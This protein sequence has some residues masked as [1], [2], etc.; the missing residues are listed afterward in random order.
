MPNTV[1]MNL[2]AVPAVSMAAPLRSM[3]CRVTCWRGGDVRLRWSAAGLLE[4]EKNFRR[5]RGCK[6]M[7]KLL[8]ALDRGAVAESA[9]AA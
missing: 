1:S 2:P 7:P 8:P 4:A 6:R 5:V 3:M 9:T